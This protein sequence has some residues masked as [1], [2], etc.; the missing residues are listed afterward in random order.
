MKPAALV[1]SGCFL[2]LL[3]GALLLVTLPR[4]GL[5]CEVLVTYQGKSFKP[6]GVKSH[7]FIVDVKKQKTLRGTGNF[8]PMNLTCEVDLAKNTSL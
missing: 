7:F 2:G 4:T 3:G 8:G 5:P 1:A 6:T